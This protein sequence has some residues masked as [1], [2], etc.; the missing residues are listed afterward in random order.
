MFFLSTFELRK[1]ALVGCGNWSGIGG[2]Y[3]SDKHTKYAKN[4]F[5]SYDN[6]VCKFDIEIFCK[7]RVFRGWIVQGRFYVQK[8]VE[9]KEKGVW[10]LVFCRLIF[11]KSC[12]F[13]GIFK[14]YYITQYSGLQNSNLRA[15]I[16]QAIH[17][18]LGEVL[19]KCFLA[20]FWAG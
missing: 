17:K 13:S 14:N 4:R 1:I 5:S 15:K 20:T 3:G 18:I 10:K 2:H 16:L 19:C 7:I 8:M 11:V 12:G 6:C 9:K